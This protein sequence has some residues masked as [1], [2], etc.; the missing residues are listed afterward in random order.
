MA[1]LHLVNEQPES[2]DAEIDALATEIAEQ[3][4]RDAA[5]AKAAAVGTRLAIVSGGGQISGPAN[6][7][8]LP[9]Q[10]ERYDDITNANR[11]LSMMG[12]DLLYCAEAGKWMIWTGTHW[13]Y[14]T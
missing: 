4:R 9:P 10:G 6:A 7:E 13:A 11:F 14:D 1:A 12:D 5:A 3:R 2:L 8:L